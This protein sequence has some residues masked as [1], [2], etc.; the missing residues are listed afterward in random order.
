MGS[1]QGNKHLDLTVFLIG[2][3]EPYL[4]SLVDLT[5]F[6]VEII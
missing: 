4:G 5:V 3:D 6:L 2:D 1:Q